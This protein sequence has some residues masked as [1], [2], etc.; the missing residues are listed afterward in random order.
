[1]TCI[2]CN[3]SCDNPLEYTTVNGTQ[4]IHWKCVQQVV[5]TYLEIDK[6]ILPPCPKLQG[7]PLEKCI[8]I[9]WDYAFTC[10]DIAIRNENQLN[11]LR[12]DI[13]MK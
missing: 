13:G 7:L 1:M 5:N 4:E 9:L 12:K 10:R 2:I 8:N 3:H 6:N 11:V